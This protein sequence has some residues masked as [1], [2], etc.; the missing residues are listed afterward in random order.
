[1][2][3]RRAAQR[4]CAL[5]RPDQVVERIREFHAAGVRHIMLDLLGPYEQRD[6]QIARFAADAMPLLRDLTQ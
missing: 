1:M 6:D 2:D 5:G 3:F 4:Y